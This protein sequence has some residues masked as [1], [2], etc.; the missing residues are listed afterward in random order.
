VLSIPDAERGLIVKAYVVL[1]PGV[2]ASSELVRELQDFV[3]QA[4]AP[5]KYHR[6]IEFCERLPETQAGKLQRFHLRQEAI[7]AQWSK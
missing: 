6:A 1:R 7:A 2:Q 5:Y 3:K 4:I